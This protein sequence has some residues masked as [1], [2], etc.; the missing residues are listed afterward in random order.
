[1]NSGDVAG[2]E[3]PRRRIFIVTAPGLEDLAAVELTSLGISSVAEAGG[4]ACDATQ[5][6]LYAANLH[7]R[8]ASRVLV[9]VADFRART[10]Y[11]L[12][13]HAGRVPWSDF[14][15]KGQPVRLRVTSKKSRLY[16]QRAI[17]QRLLTAIGAPAAAAAGDEET[18]G[19]GEQLF[20]VRFLYDRCVISADSSGAL[21]HLRGY[22]R[23]LAR[24]P[25]RETMAAAMLLGSGWDGR[26]PLIDPLCGSGTIPI[27]SALIAR[28]V[29][30][31]L[32]G[33]GREP[34]SYAFMSW[35][36]FDAAR[37][38]ELVKR[39]GAEIL[40]RAPGRIVASDRDEGAIA[41]TEANA[42]RAGVRDDIELSGRA[43]SAVEAVGA[44]GWMVTNPPYGIRVGEA[45]RLRDLYATL[46]QVARRALPGGR[47]V[48]L[49]ANRRLE[50]QLGM[51]LREV[52]STRNGGIPVRLLE[53]PI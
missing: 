26:A 44:G 22:R 36:G 7:L 18:E 19:A 8:T 34:R 16:H 35:P 23:A 38:R 32:A 27:E 43:V 21:L 6:Q 39:A 51:R 30:P 41:A 25:L 53:G 48:M 4:L 37:F 42:A 5:E 33:P 50:G 47:V 46:G 10:F 17:E 14:L 45:E 9:R 11:E 52:L 1:M 29:A 15:G 28:R 20:I 13:R 49:S 24:A 40:S 31:G 12:E 2:A 3:D